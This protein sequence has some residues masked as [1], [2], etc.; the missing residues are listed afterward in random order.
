MSVWA[1]P[2][3]GSPSARCNRISLIF[4]LAI[5]TTLSHAAEAKAI[6][7]EFERGLQARRS[8]SG[9]L[10]GVGPEGV[11]YAANFLLQKPCSFRVI[12]GQVELHCNGKVQF[13]HLV[14][15]K[16]YFKRDVSTKLGSGVPGGLDAFFG[17]PTGSLAP[18]FVHKTE[19]RMQ[20]VNGHQCAA[21]ALRFESFGRDDRMVFYVDRTSK[22]ILG[23]DQVFGGTKTYLR[24][25][26]LAFD[27]PVP[28]GAFDW[29]PTPD[30]K[31]QRQTGGEGEP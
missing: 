14:A 4:A 15:E 27:I 28:K 11:S 2:K 12:D 17:F 9:N 13:N 5:G 26:H 6:F 7:A 21:K 1:L 30:L 8:A 23:W 24:F 10:V 16:Q 3:K 19:F 20:I 29:K 31:E 22:Q 18:Y 25:S